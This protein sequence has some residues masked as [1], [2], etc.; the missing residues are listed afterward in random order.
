MSTS[1]MSTGKTCQQLP[2]FPAAAPVYA[3]TMR[4]QRMKQRR[5]RILLWLERNNAWVNNYIPLVLLVLLCNMDIQK[6]NSFD[7]L[8]KYLTK[9]QNK[10]SA[11]AH[12]NPHVL[13]RHLFA[14]CFRIAAEQS[15]ISFAVLLVSVANSSTLRTVGIYASCC[16]LCVANRCQQVGMGIVKATQRS[17]RF[18]AAGCSFSVFAS[19]A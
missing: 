16:E 10:F 19:D 6:I 14:Q 15:A 18:F 8:V 2:G 4:L 9:Y 11:G 3:D 17:P 5:D 1:N 7:A 13:G 12:I